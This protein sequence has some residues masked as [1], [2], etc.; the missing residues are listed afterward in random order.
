MADHQPLVSVIVPCRDEGR[1]I[2]ACL[3]SILAN[4]YPSE[5]LEVL[6]VDGMS[7]DDTPAVVE[8][9]AANHPLLRMITN[10]KKITPAALN[11]GIAA[12]KGSIVIRMDAHVEYPRDYISALVRLLQESG[13][14]NVG[15]VCQTLPANE[16]SVAKAIALGM[17]H[18]LGVGNSRFRIGSAEDRWVDTVPFGC[19]RRDV[20]DR[21]G[22]FDEELVR[23]QDDELNL[24]LIKHGGRILLSPRVVCKYFARDCLAKLWRMYYQYGFF[25]PL[26]VRKVGGVMTFR[27]IAPPLLVICLA[28]TALAALLSLALAFPWKIVGSMAFAGVAGSYL[29]AII[30]CAAGAA[31]RHGL[32]VAAALTLVFPTLHISYGVGY[33]QGAVAFLLLR[34]G[35]RRDAGAVPLTR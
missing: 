17:S 12:A 6:V 21:I 18:P 31:R 23:N 26:V 25:K 22:L 33:L 11:L 4:D 10:E 1:W 3:D 32:A 8:S 5:C 13:A 30:V 16:S 7:I 15:G 28:A 2:A 34:Q 14:D 29:L 27:Q 19:Y 20:F 24:R 35:R 9:T